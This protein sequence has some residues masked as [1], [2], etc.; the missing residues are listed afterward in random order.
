MAPLFTSPRAT[1]P[2][3]APTRGMTRPEA[4]IIAGRIASHRRWERRRRTLRL[5]ATLF[6]RRKRARRAAP[7]PVGSGQILAA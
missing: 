5:R 1:T 2:T 3:L 7:A 6:G 4:E